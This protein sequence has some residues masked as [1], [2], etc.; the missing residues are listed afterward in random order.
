MLWIGEVED[1]K[2]VGV[3]KY[4]S[5]Y[6]RKNLFWTSRILISRFTSG[7][8]KILTG[9]FM[10]QVTTA[11]GKDQSEMKIT[12]RRRQIARMIC[13][14]FQKSLATMKPSWASE[15]WSEVQLKNDNVQ[16]FDS[17]WDE[18][19]SAV[20]DRL[21]DKILKR[22]HNIRKVGGI[23]ICVSSL[24]PRDN[25]GRQKKDDYC[26]LELMAQGHLA[27]KIKGLSSKRE[28]ETRTDLQ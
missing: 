17:K 15:V 3:L 16:A 26:R 6:N 18:V 22:M 12:Y 25:I 27:Q 5:I 24:R 23:E 19:L 8:V 14:F 21:A 9:S 2:C 28:I 10:K 7:L 11:E 4:F 13:G 20:T 1:V